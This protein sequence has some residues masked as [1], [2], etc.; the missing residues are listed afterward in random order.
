MTALQ[1]LRSTSQ[2]GAGGR[3]EAYSGPS[4]EGRAHKEPSLNGLAECSRLGGRP[5]SAS[6]SKLAKPVQNCR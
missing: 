2:L 3:T 1:R 4:G 5:G 6:D